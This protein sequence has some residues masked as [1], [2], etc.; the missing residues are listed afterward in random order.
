M[1]F[2]NDDFADGGSDRVADV[3]VA[4]GS[5]DDIAARVHERRQAGANDVCVQIFGNAR[6]LRAQWRELA[7]AFTAV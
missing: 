2:N 3:L 6:D 7:P 4:W 1:G 5:P